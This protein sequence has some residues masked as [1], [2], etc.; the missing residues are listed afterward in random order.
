MPTQHQ[1][2][3]PCDTPLEVSSQR[4]LGQAEAGRELGRIA[5]EA[6]QERAADAGLHD[7]EYNLGVLLQQSGEA[8]R[9]N[10]GGSGPPPPATRAQCGHWSA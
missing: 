5:G 2:P 8:K 10:A 1:D 9:P 3:V 6:D 4:G 7:A